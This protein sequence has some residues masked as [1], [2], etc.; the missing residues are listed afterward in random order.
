[1]LS[2]GV[3]AFPLSTETLSTHL[4]DKSLLRKTHSSYGN[5][6]ELNTTILYDG[7][8]H[9]LIMLKL[10]KQKQKQTKNQKHGRALNVPGNTLAQHL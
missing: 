2:P 5:I 6:L 9:L 8:V 10:Q 3:T 4:T 1:M 7:F